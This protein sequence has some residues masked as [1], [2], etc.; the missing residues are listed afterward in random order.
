MEKK[1][2]MAIILLC[3]IIVAIIITLIMIFLIRSQILTDEEYKTIDENGNYK[4]VIDVDDSLQIKKVDNNIEYF[5]VKDCIDSY[6][7]F[8][9]DLLYNQ[10]NQEMDIN[11]INERM[12]S[13]IPKFVQKSLNL[14]SKN[15]YRTIGLPDKYI[16]INK[17][18]V[19]KQVSDENNKDT[20]TNIYAYIVEGI[21]IDRDNFSK[22]NFKMIVLLDQ[23]NETFYIIPQKYIEDN[24][25]QTE[26]G[27]E[28]NIYSQSEIENNT[29]NTYQPKIYKDQ[30]ICKEYFNIFRLDLEYDMK[31]AYDS[32]DKEYREK[33]FGNYNNFAKY[34]EENNLKNISIQNYLVNRYNDYNEYVCKDQYGNFYIFKENA[35]MDYSVTLDTYTLEQEKFIEEYEK[36]TNQRKVMMNI[37]K[38]FQMINAKDYNTAYKLLD[39]NFK[40]NYFRTVDIFENYMKQRVFLYND[41]EYVSYNGDISGVFTYTLNLKNRLDNTQEIEFSIVMQLKEGTDFVMSFPVY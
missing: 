35:A 8:S 15:L 31:Y 5:R 6:I 9:Q 19:S 30:D 4:D 23:F 21:F 39:N 18:T 36:S 26:E 38:F 40:N 20:E 24:K 27:K 1:I 29:Y 11:L 2:K 10:N 14:N 25:I 16:R 3:I 12:I 13:I 28:L 33:R 37:D 17:M 34:I 7:M 32:L 22:E 41:V